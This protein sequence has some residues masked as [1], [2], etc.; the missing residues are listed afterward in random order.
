[1]E[2][3]EV[4]DCFRSVIKD[5]EKGKKHKGLLIEKVN[6]E[7]AKTY[8]IK[9]KQNIQLS[10]LYKKNGFDYLIPEAWFYTLYYCALAIL[11]KFGITSRSQ[12]S[13]AIFLKYVKEK[14]L[15]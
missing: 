3:S 4:R 2:K 1:M 10:E 7:M 8:I 12:R 15:I 6:D 13:T 11:L 5:E 9:A 14:G